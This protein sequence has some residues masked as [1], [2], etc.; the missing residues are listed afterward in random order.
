MKH[1]ML[2]I[3]NIQTHFI[4]KEE[5]DDIV[6]CWHNWCRK[7]S[8]T[9]YL[10]DHLGTEAFTNP[11]MITKYYLYFIKIL[12]NTLFYPNLFLNKR[13][14]SIKQAYTDDNNILDR[15]I[16]EDLHFFHLNADLGRHSN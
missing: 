11:L 13:F 12:Q 10:S 16:F 2:Y 1:H 8:L 4:V 3:N 14:D 7:T 15:S 5:T 9:K 6:T